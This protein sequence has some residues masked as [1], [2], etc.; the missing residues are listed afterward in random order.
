MGGGFV[1]NRGRESVDASAIRRGSSESR[2]GWIGDGAVEGNDGFDWRKWS[3]A[4][5][6]LEVREEVTGKRRD[7]KGKSVILREGKGMDWSAKDSLVGRNGF[8]EQR[9]IW[10]GESVRVA[11]RSEGESMT[12]IREDGQMADEKEVKNSILM[13]NEDFDGSKGPAEQT[14]MIKEKILWMQSGFGTKKD[15]HN[16]REIGRLAALEGSN[17]RVDV[18]GYPNIASE[19]KD[20]HTRRA[21]TDQLK[22]PPARSGSNAVKGASV[23]KSAWWPR[24]LLSYSPQIPAYSFPCAPGCASSFRL[25]STA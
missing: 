17:V 14:K 9:E 24:T 6:D 4:V 13:G 15:R 21:Q 2:A 3:T 23:F 1:G 19:D 16:T 7:W 11:E 25:L 12:W 10:M 20:A 18:D 22:E 8:G 5:G